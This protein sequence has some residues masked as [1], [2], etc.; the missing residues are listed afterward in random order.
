MLIHVTQRHIDAG[1]V[2]HGNNCPIALAIIEQSKLVSIY[3]G[4]T[5]IFSSEPLTLTTDAIADLPSQ[6]ID[7][8]ALFDKG[9]PAAPFSFELEGVQPRETQR[10]LAAPDLLHDLNS[11]RADASRPTGSEEV[12]EDA[13][14]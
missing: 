12:F 7:F 1:C 10:S 5:R 11:M 3:V 4:K 9:R 2:K 13:A 14:A 8:I 6:A